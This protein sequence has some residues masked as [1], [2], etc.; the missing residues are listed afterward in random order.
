MEF[1]KKLKIEL[2]YAPSITVLG[3]YTEEN[4]IWKDT[5]TPVFT[6]ALFTIA[7]TWMK[8]KC[9]LTEEW[10]KKTWYVYTEEHYSSIRKNEI[11]PFAATW[12]DLEIIASD[13]S[14]TGSDKYHLYAKYKTTVPMNLF[15]NK[16]QNH[17]YRKQ[18]CNHQRGKWEVSGGDKLG[19]WN[20]HTHTTQ[21]IID[22]KALLY[23]TRELL[24]SILL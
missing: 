4:M 15:T 23:S 7:K 13:I 17:R 2:T 21:C 22:N 3:I 9:P 14:Q 1:L 5:F 24:F 11:M 6:A 10:I 16:K 20:Q 18:T 8:P 12:M 19:D